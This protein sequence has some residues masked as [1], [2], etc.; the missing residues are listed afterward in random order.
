MP[1]I[2]AE[3]PLQ[4]ELAEVTQTWGERIDGG[5]NLP[6]NKVWVHIFCVHYRVFNSYSFATSI[7]EVQH[8]NNFMFIFVIANHACQTFQT[9]YWRFSTTGNNTTG[10]YI[11]C[12][13]TLANNHLRSDY[14]RERLITTVQGTVDIVTLKDLEEVNFEDTH[15]DLHPY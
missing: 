11:N 9:S 6:Q 15:P 13:L 2:K 8:P 5:F 14:S 7:Q 1:N 4:T 12:I 10:Y 3:S